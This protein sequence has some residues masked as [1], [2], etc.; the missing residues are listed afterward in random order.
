MACPYLTYCDTYCKHLHL[1]FKLLSY[2][3]LYVVYSDHILSRCVCNI[4]I[5]LTCDPIHEISLFSLKIF[6][7]SYT[8]SH[9]VLPHFKCTGFTY[10][11]INSIQK[12]K[13]GKITVWGWFSCCIGVIKTIAYDLL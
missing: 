13:L 10:L 1:K 3:L 11:A 5:L 4:Q 2:I 6:K 8:I 9:K 7:K 12:L